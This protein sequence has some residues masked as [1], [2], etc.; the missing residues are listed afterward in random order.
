MKTL[1]IIT[2]LISPIAVISNIFVINARFMRDEDGAS[3]TLV[4]ILMFVASL[5]TFIYTKRKKWL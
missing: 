2:F 1:T 5:I 3:Y 4:L